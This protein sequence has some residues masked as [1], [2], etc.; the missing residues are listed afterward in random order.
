MF[1]PR[2]YL[3]LADALPRMALPRMAS[4]RIPSQHELQMPLLQRLLLFYAYSALFCAVAY[5]LLLHKLRPGLPRLLVALPFL[6]RGSLPGARQTRANRRR[7]PA[8][9]LKPAPRRRRP[10]RPP[11]WRCPRCWWTGSRR[12]WP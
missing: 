6:V 9:A 5:F 3:Y 8:E 7:R 4:M 2:N 1:G 12:R 11:T 10:R